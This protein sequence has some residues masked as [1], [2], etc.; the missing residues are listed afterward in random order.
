MHSALHDS[1]VVFTTAA[2]LFAL[3]ATPIRLKIISALAEGERNVS[4]LLDDIETTQP[5]MSQ[6]L[7]MLHRAGVVS[8][9]RRATQIYYRLESDRAASLCR[10]VCAEIAQEIDH[11]VLP[12]AQA[13]GAPPGTARP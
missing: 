10:K 7:S 12:P 3:L 1:D 9:R 8:R 2:G 11:P 6:H 13:A 5:N 4:Q